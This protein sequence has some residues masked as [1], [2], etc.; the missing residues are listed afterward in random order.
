MSLNQYQTKANV[1][2]KKRESLEKEEADLDAKIASYSTLL[3]GQ[4]M[5]LKSANNF[6][7]EYGTTV[8]SNKTISEDLQKA[9]VD[10]PA[11]HPA[12]GRLTCAGRDRR[13]AK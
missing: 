6:L 12:A 5:I 13:K 1:L 7:T 3:K 9:L 8:M 10:S 11:Q 2:L 4:Q